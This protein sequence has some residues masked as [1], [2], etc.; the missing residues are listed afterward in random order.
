[1][2]FASHRPPST[3]H[4]PSSIA[5]PLGTVL[6][7]RRPGAPKGNK[8]AVGH[9]APRGN[10]NGV[11]HGAPRGNRNAV[12]FGVYTRE[13][14]RPIVRHPGLSLIETLELEEHR[15][16]LFVRDEIAS[17]TPV[18]LDFR[19]S[20]S[21]L[22]AVTIAV[23]R[24]E[25]LHRRIFAIR[26]SHAF[27]SELGRSIARELHLFP[28]DEQES[29]LLPSS[30]SRDNCLLVSFFSNAPDLSNKSDVS[31]VSV[32]GHAWCVTDQERRVHDN[33]ESGCLM[34]QPFGGNSPFP[35]PNAGV[36]RA[37]DG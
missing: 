12:K 9:G 27:D 33:L 30:A 20:L 36:G 1:M 26:N 8:N 11:G 21:L 15:L 22:R 35:L 7:P 19:S 13:F 18:G 32:V 3:V 16:R 24:I 37:G 14:A 25:R 29:G 6:P 17:V 31:D 2:I 28:T 23:G 10:K 5:S 34:K 4:R